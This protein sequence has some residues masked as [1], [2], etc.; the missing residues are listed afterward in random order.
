MSFRLSLGSMRGMERAASCGQ[1]T[2]TDTM[3]I[4]SPALLAS[5]RPA[6]MWSRDQ[7]VLLLRWVL[8]VATSYLVLFSRPLGETPPIASLFVAL[9]LGTNI[10]L[11]ELMPRLRRHGA[12]DWTLVAV[13]TVAVALAMLLTENASSDFFVLY[14]VVVFVSAL[15]ERVGLVAVATLLIVTTYLYTLAQFRDLGALFEEGYMLRVPFLFAVALFF[16]QLVHN[17]RAQER[18]AEERRAR[19][20]RMELLSGITHDLKNP[21]GVIQ[22]L[23]SMMLDG[24]GG[25]LNE[26][27]T[28]LT[29]RIHATTRHLITLSENLIDAERIE[30]GR[31]ALQPRPTDVRTVATH[32]LEMARSASQLKSITLY[33]DIEPALPLLSIDPVQ[34]ERVISNLLGNAIKFTPK[35][36][37]VTLAVRRRANSLSLTVR[38]NGPG[39]EASELP[40][41]FEK[42]HHGAGRNPGAGSGLGLFIVKAVVEAQGGSVHIVSNVAEGTTVTVCLPIA[43][44]VREPIGRP[45]PDHRAA[46]PAAI[47]AERLSA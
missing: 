27:Q 28:E 29:H 40:R 18:Q 9:Y 15:G 46:A 47:V 36:G 17:A 5:D 3:A 32:A 31:L 22:S 20:I 8:I 2:R 14:F 33:S 34:T 26:P 35:G 12:F 11:T 13:D 4:E 7:L 38:D 39:L 1:M 24:E 43:P 10:A 21:L 23:S 25:A 16:G 42:Y 19:A 44:P 45:L 37:I 6:P 30:A 41:I